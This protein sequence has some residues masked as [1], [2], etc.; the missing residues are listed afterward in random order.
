M[1]EPSHAEVL[2]MIRDNYDPTLLDMARRYTRTAERTAA[3]R[4]HLAFNLRLKRYGLLPRSLWVRPLIN[5]QEGRDIA[6]RASRRFLMARIAQNARTVRNLELD[7]LF[8]R[9]QLQFHLH[10]PDTEAM[11]MIR[12]RSFREKTTKCK[13]RQKRKFDKLLNRGTGDVRARRSKDKWVVNLSSRPL[14]TAEESVLAKGLNFAPAPRRIPVPD[15]VAAVEGGLS[16]IGSAAAQL[17][18]TRITGCLAKARP[19]LPIFPQQNRKP[20]EA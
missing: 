18:R 20:S 8:Q 2:H 14:S 4:Q 15:I 19:P 6:N 1:Q 16:R 11:E 5:S 17:A 10:P 13:E 7:L 12:E 3:H 9:R